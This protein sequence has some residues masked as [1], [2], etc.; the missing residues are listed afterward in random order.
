MS[1]YSPLSK[2]S[3]SVWSL[4]CSCKLAWVPS[5]ALCYQ[6]TS[7]ALIACFISLEV[8]MGFSFSF[9]GASLQ[10]HAVLQVPSVEGSARR[11]ASSCLRED[12]LICPH[13]SSISLLLENVSCLLS[14]SLCKQSP[15]TRQG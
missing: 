10:H 3:F 5:N 11:S 6:Q 8:I 4:S 14:E 1:E 12:R 7:K 9:S 15:Y 2:P 13:L